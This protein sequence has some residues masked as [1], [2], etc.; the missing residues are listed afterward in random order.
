M[1][2]A[3]LWWRGLHLALA[4]APA[5]ALGIAGAA[6]GV[7][8]AVVGRARPPVALHLVRESDTSFP[9]GHAT[10]STAVFVAVA[11]VVALFVLRRPLVRAVTVAGAALLSGAIGASR[12]VLG[13]HW[14]TDVLAGLALGLATS[15]VVTMAATAVTRLTPRPST[16]QRG[17]DAPRRG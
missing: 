4:L 9:S 12:L 1:V 8:K 6:V 15:L 17:C 16:S 3:L 5:F 14:P 13:V 2:G 7:I 11:L 10:D